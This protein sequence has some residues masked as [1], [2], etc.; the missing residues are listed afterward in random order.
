MTSEF[1]TSSRSGCRLTT[2]GFRSARLK[3]IHSVTEPGVNSAQPLIDTLNSEPFLH[4]LR[5]KL[6]GVVRHQEEIGQ[7][8][9]FGESL[10]ALLFESQYAR[11]AEEFICRRIRTRKACRL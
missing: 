11:N 10:D 2:T 3:A 7:L 5:V 6:I 4:S 8:R 1:L 9:R